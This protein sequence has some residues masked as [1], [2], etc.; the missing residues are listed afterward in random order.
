M[1]VD[2]YY[3]P[4][5]PGS[6][7]EA[8]HRAARIGY[9]GFFTTETSHEPFIPL[10][11]AAQAEP[12][13]TL[14]TAIAVAFPRSPM[15]TA[16]L[17]WDLASLSE[18]R[19]VLGLGTQVRAHV[20]RRFSTEWTSPGP[21]L[22]EYVQA[23]RAIWRSFQDSEP[24]RFDGEHYRFSLLTPFFDPGPIA[25]PDIPIAIAGVG[26]YLSSLAG[27]LCDGFHVHPFHTVRYLDEVVLPEM[28]GGAERAGRTLEDVERISTVF[29]VTGRNDEEMAQMRETVRQQVAFYA[30]TPSY[31]PVLDVQ[32]WDFGEE[33][34]RLSKRGDWAGMA[35]LVGD[36]VVDE[37]AVTAPPDRLGRAVRE[38]YGDRIQRVGFYAVGGDVMFTDEE[39]SEI[40][41]GAR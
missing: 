31:R 22:R 27:E 26:P 5:P 15:V 21:R 28:R 23:L 37:I 2:Y 32:G 20:T 34:T 3:P 1:K 7:V 12:D 30:S 16:Q 10:A 38:R 11:L 35:A 14:G 4:L 6:A 25:H 41:A 24:L 9:D 39:W 40:V 13:L 8:A 19:F 18:G 36:D 29:V 17:A 33:L